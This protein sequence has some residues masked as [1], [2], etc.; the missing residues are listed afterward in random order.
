MLLSSPSL[1]ILLLKLGRSS[2]LP[3]LGVMVALALSSKSIV[4]LSFFCICV[5]VFWTDWISAFW[6][7]YGEAVCLWYMLAVMLVIFWLYIAVIWLDKAARIYYPPCPNGLKCY[8]F[9]TLRPLWSVGSSKP[10]PSLV[11][12][13]LLIL[14]RLGWT[15][16]FFCRAEYG[17]SSTAAFFFFFRVFRRPPSP[18][19]PSSKPPISVTPSSSPTSWPNYKKPLWLTTVTLVGLRLSLS[20][21]R[22]LIAPLIFVYVH[23]SL[24]IPVSSP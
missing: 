24:I 15:A 17:S 10:A 12:T 21:K 8:W 6:C 18:G 23:L 9:P 19:A 14:P 7:F 4:D 22:A 3:Y 16:W 5:C 1:L 13:P 11:V 2:L 20:S